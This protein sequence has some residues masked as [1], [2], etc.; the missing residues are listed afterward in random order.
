[1]KVIVSAHG[2]GK[3]TML[4]EWLMKSKENILIVFSSQ[5][6]QQIIKEY[7]REELATHAPLPRWVDRIYTLSELEQQR[8]K[9]SGKETIAIDNVDIFLSNFFRRQI[10]IIS[11]TGDS[12]IIDIENSAEETLAEASS[13]VLN[14]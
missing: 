14:E 5:E 10:S 4:M 13:R 7:A 6:K 2:K 12:E 3:T 8:G 9:L 1:M 11:L